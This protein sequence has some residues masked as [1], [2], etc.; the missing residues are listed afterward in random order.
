[1]INILSEEMEPQDILTKK[2]ESTTYLKDQKFY[3][4]SARKIK[5]KYQNNSA[6]TFM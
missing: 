6:K 3:F 5:N 1:M 2:G 4:V